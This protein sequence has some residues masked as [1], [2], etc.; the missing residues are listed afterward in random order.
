MPPVPGQAWPEVPLEAVRS[1]CAAVPRPRSETVTDVGRPSSGAE[2]SQGRFQPVGLLAGALHAG[3]RCSYWLPGCC[4]RI[5]PVVQVAGM[6]SCRLTSCSG[7]VSAPRTS[8]ESGGAILTFQSESMGLSVDF[9]AISLIFIAPPFRQ[10]SALHHKA[11]PLVESHVLSS[12]ARDSLCRS[13]MRLPESRHKGSIFKIR[14][15]WKSLFVIVQ[16]QA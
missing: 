15:R 9:G 16:I 1:F 7:G 4:R 5:A 11:S 10:L 8:K 2:R 13:R 14:V 12:R 6:T 3:R